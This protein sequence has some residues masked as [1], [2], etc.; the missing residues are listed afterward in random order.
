M[1]LSLWSAASASPCGEPSEADPLPCLAENEN[2]QQTRGPIT[3][4]SLGPA[5]VDPSTGA[6][7]SA[8]VDAIGLAIA[9]RGNAGLVHG[10]VDFSEAITVESSSVVWITHAA[11][12]NAYDAKVSAY[13]TASA[14][15][16]ASG[17]AEIFETYDEEFIPYAWTSGQCLGGPKDDWS[18]WNGDGRT[19]S[20][21]P[22]A[23]ARQRTTP[24]LVGFGPN[25]DGCSGVL[26]ASHYI[27]TAAHCV[28][29]DDGN[30]LTDLGEAQIGSVAGFNQTI[31]AD[32][33]HLDFNRWNGKVRT[34]YALV[35]LESTAAA[36]GVMLLSQQLDSNLE[37]LNNAY[38]LG[39]P[40]TKD[41]SSCT[42]VPSGR[43]QLSIAGVNKV[44]SHTSGR[45]TVWPYFDTGKGASG[46]P[47]YYCPGGSLWDWCE[48]G[49]TGYV[50]GL[51]AGAKEST[52]EVHGARVRGRLRDWA[53]GVI[54]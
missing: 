7:S 10:T 8:A 35:E 4:R 13:D 53:L 33:I 18:L 32:R 40:S 43:T 39:Y 51:L 42:Q 36:Y 28:T 47:F 38:H 26:I 52:G 6:I 24:F 31:D 23:T 22:V 9:Q 46:G 2:N 48:N 29:D 50:F 37:T 34:D 21:F 3:W 25:P 54:P 14:E 1:I 17:P 19:V 16:I 15:P 12:W 5:H 30:P 20:A 45:G 41:G 27:L 11:D 49:D 44:R